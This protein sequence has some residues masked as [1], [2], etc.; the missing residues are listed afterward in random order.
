MHRRKLRRVNH[1]RKLHRAT[2]TE[3]INV[4]W[5]GCCFLAARGAI[6]GM[7]SNT[8]QLLVSTLLRGLDTRKS[9]EH[10]VR[11]LQRMV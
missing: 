2:L 4:R 5:P 8:K 6:A 10:N 7:L 1:R 3:S 11:S 9:M